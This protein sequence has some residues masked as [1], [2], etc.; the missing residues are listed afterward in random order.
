MI[1]STG[2]LFKQVNFTDSSYAIGP[3]EGSAEYH[4]LVRAAGNSHVA[5]V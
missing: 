4:G 1:T 2:R 3:L 5:P